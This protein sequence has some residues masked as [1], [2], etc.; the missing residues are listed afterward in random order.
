MGRFSIILSVVFCGVFLLHG[1]DIRFDEKLSGWSRSKKADISL[2]GD[3]S[4]EPAVRLKDG[5]RMFRAFDLESDSI[6]ELSFHVKG[7]GLPAKD[8]D[9]ARVMVNGGKIWQRFTSDAKKGRPETGTFDWKKGIGKIDTSRTGTKVRL[10][11]AAG[12]AGTVWYSALKLVKKSVSAKETSF[13][14]KY[15]ETVKT[16]LL[17]PQG[18]FGF[19]EPG[20]KPVFKILLDSR[21][22]DLEYEL[23]VKDETGR[24]VQTLP[25]RKAEEEV[26]L[27]GQPC[28]YYVAEADFFCKGKKVYSVQS[29]FVSAEKISRRDPFFQMGFG[30]QPDMVEGIRR[31]GVGTISLKLSG[32][33]NPG[34]V[35]KPE[36]IFNW[37][38]T[39]RVKPYM[40]AGGFEFSANIGVSLLK[41]LRSPREIEEGWPLINDALL[42]HYRKFLTLALNE[43]KGKVRTWAIQQETPSNARMPKFVGTWTEAMANFVVLVRMGSRQIRKEIPG[44]KIMIGG[45]NIR[46]TLSDI[47]RITLTDLV[48]EFD[49]Y[50]IDAYTGNWKLTLGEP[51]LPEAELMDFYRDA[52]ALSESLGK[53]K[54]IR[55]EELGYCINYGAA[56]DK[57]LAVTQAELTAR[58]LIITKAGPVS[59]FELH[60]PTKSMTK[61]VP[62]QADCMTTVWKPV[63]FKGKCYHLPLP[64]GAMYATA[65][66]Q[67]AFARSPHFFSQESFYG[68]VFTRPDKKTL[69]VLWNIE[70][71]K[72]LRM[73]LPVRTRMVN[74]YGREALLAPGSQTLRIGKAPL[75]LSMDYPAEKLTKDISRVLHEN[76]PE[77]KGA[78]YAFS[79]DEARVFIRNLTPRTRTGELAGAGKLTLPP[80]RTVSFSVRTSGKS[81]SFT[82]DDGRK[83]EFAIDRNAYP[84]TRVK[85]K[86]ILDGSGSWLN[87]LP[88]GVLKYPDDIRPKSALQPEL[89]YFKTDF[90]PGGH[91]V[92]AKYWTA[93]DDNNFYIAAEVDDPVHLQRFV[94][95]DLWRDDCLQ[96][97]FS[98]ADAVPK[99]LRNTAEQQPVS[100]LNFGIALTPR[101]PIAAK[102]VGK[103][104]GT[105]S[106]KFNVTRKDGKTFY[107]A[108]IPF[109]ELGG[110]PSRFGFVIFDN[111]YVGKKSAPYWLEFSPGIA[112]GMD[113]GKLKLIQYR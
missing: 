75:Y 101:G 43:L 74:M 70:G 42:D 2:D 12:S 68:C 20:E 29:G 16:A 18:V 27:A 82:A 36:K 46:G 66:S 23:K 37:L 32:W 6:Y 57:G 47:E 100:P 61:D 25:R 33:N 7:Q 56:F 90:N 14:R 105:G 77:F 104:P 53:G 54:I 40:D 84:V 71:E 28:G 50:V 108:A 65:A 106:V 5:A 88:E 69:L 81:C 112:G 103:V 67:L 62:D 24:T 111:N 99:E 1:E 73:N 13:R 93:Y 22:K 78:G 4:G 102:M 87:G 72:A 96:I 60:T 39:N 41:A 55:N 30:L 83:Y 48:R 109:K 21:E 97:V 107:E 8:N 85:G 38:Y 10:Y 26:T 94:G 80:D 86:V 63:V 91:N 95:Q 76:V 49:G 79:K 19:F 59:G 58:Q 44:A 89:S 52:S 17:I 3:F 45:C 34:A 9:G 98:S 113:S 51:T 35:G 11:L 15:G 92:S 64:G 31:I 110:R